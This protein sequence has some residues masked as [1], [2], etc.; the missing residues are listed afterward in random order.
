M[1]PDHLLGLPNAQGPRCPLESEFPK[2][3]YAIGNWREACERLEEIAGIFE[4]RG[5]LPPGSQAE[6][7]QALRQAG[8]DALAKML[9]DLE[10]AWDAEP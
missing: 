4:D 1:K 6:M 2:I 7:R 8:Q 3:S 9:D 5:G 10:A